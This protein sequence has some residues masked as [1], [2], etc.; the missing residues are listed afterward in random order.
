MT[1]MILFV[2]D[3][4]SDQVAAVMRM[5]TEITRADADERLR[6][7]QQV[8]RDLVAGYQQR[9]VKPPRPVPAVPSPDAVPAY[10]EQLAA[11]A[12]PDWSGI[13]LEYPA[14]PDEQPATLWSGVNTVAAARYGT[15]CKT[16]TK[17]GEMIAATRSHA[18][19]KVRV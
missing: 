16:T 2:G 1:T 10:R 18:A 12:P 19:A 17:G 13:I 8:A 15:S 4:P 5:A 11:F 6:E 9:R 3:A 14:M 7:R